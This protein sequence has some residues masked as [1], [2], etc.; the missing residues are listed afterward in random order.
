MSH[1]SKTLRRH[2]PRRAWSGYA[3]P[4]EL[5]RMQFNADMRLPE[6]TTR[7]VMFFTPRSGSS[8][9]AD[10]LSRTKRMGR[11]T[12]CFNPNFMPRMT[13]SVNAASL[14]EYCAVLPRRLQS[15]GSFG[16]QITLFQMRAVFSRDKVFLNRYAD[17]PWIWLIRSD[18]VRQAISLYKMEMGQITHAPQM[19]GRSITQAEQALSYNA[20]RIRYWLEHVLSMEEETEALFRHAGQQPLRMNYERNAEMK[21]NHIANVIARHA[22]RDTMRMKA[23]QSPHSKIATLQNTEFAE[24]FRD[25]NAELLKRVTEERAERVEK[26]LYYGPK[27]SY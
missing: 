27:G 16:F 6:P 3:A 26:S 20:K 5:D 23:L 11:V 12:E 22:G 19:K 24:R 8:W 21:P 1:L 17:Q 10:L 14:D 13:R 9:V 18:I 7:Y 25:E 2:I 15:G 4:S